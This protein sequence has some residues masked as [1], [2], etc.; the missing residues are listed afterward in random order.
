MPHPA[1]RRF[2]MAPRE[3]HLKAVK[4]ILAYLK[5]VSK[6]RV[7]IDTSYPNH[8]E[9]PVEEHSNWKDFYPVAEEEIP[10]NLPMSRVSKA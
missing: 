9:Y 8:P 4:R 6:G 3:G 10:N 1:M 7:I 5:T 2:N